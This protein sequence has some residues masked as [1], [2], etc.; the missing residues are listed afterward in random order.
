MDITRWSITKSDW[1]YS[2]QKKME[3]LWADG[4]SDNEPLIAKYRLKLKKEGKTTGPFRYDLN[5][6]PYDYTLEGRD[7]FKVLDLIDSWVELSSVTQ[8]CLTLC[9]PMNRSTPGLPVHHK[10]PEFTQTHAH[11]VGDAIQPSHPLLSPSPPALNPS[12]HQGLF[13]WVNSLHEV[14]KV[15]EFQFQHQSLQWTPRTDLL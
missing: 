1:L 15:L 11:R 13:Q 4:G 10:L 2:L 3:R 9:D 6:I 12:Q 8:S 7:K 5:Q 14:A